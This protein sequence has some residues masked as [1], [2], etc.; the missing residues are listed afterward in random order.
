M[1]P[2]PRPAVRRPLRRLAGLVALAGAAALAGCGHPA[3]Q[4][5]CDELIAKSA[6]I[7]LR[8][9]NVTD[10]KTIAERTSAARATPKGAELSS[11][12]V[13]KRITSSALA[14]VRRAKTADEFDHCL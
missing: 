1:R 12:C 4:E 5:E 9:Q 14:C 11:R 2:P 8:G 6:E 7:E 13:G 3:T 10:P